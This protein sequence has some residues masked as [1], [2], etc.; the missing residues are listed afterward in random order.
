MERFI[1]NSIQIRFRLDLSSC[2]LS[3]HGL[4]K[5]ISALR[6]STEKKLKI[7]RYL[8][9][10]DMSASFSDIK[11]DVLPNV[12]ESTLY[13]YLKQLENVGLITSSYNR[14]KRYSLGSTGISYQLRRSFPRVRTIGG[15][16]KLDWNSTYI[17]RSL[18]EALSMDIDNSKKVVQRVE[19]VVTK[20]GVNSL[21]IVTIRALICDILYELG[22]ERESHDYTPIG[23]PQEKAEDISL[24]KFDEVH[25]LTVGKYFSKLFMLKLLPSSV[26]KLIERGEYIY[27]HGLTNVLNPLNVLHD[28]RPLFLEGL[29]LPDHRVRPAKSLDVAFS[30]IIALLGF[31]RNDCDGTQCINHLNFYIAPYVE[32]EKERF[33][34]GN[35]MEHLIELCDGFIKDL[36]RTYL[37]NVNDPV[38]PGVILDLNTL[39]MSEKIVVAR[40]EIMEDE[41]YERYDE[42]AEIFTEAFLEALI[43]G[44]EEQNIYYYPKIFIELNEDT[45]KNKINS[46]I[47]AKLFE[48]I[49]KSS[50][51]PIYIANRRA[52]VGYLPDLTSINVSEKGEDS[53]KGMGCM[54]AVTPN[55]LK[56]KSGIYKE[57]IDSV[58]SEIVSMIEYIKKLALWKKDKVKSRIRT[59]RIF[60]STWKS[61]LPTYY[62]IQ[63]SIACVRL[64]GLKTLAKLMGYSVEK[65]AIKELERLLYNL[66]SKMNELSQV[67]G[68]KFT[69]AQTPSKSGAMRFAK[70]GTESANLF[71]AIKTPPSDES[72]F[73]ERILYEARLQQLLDGGALTRLSYYPDRYSLER[74]REDLQICF[75]NKLK[76]ITFNRL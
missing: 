38:Y 27:I 54:L 8:S 51:T 16:K 1:S 61:A 70:I 11:T 2:G 50:P 67:T 19:E 29:S 42:Y 66:N 5:Q 26:R 39:P 28:V 17:L 73:L 45:L 6:R 34:R 32:N 63:N 43:R 76:L 48:I 30:Q 10:P 33:G 57:G 21:S 25:K 13:A 20:M 52:D 37:M 72:H 68:M 24:R 14:P 55:I 56:L 15:R 69:L 49:K 71:S 35:F 62:D 22:M 9:Q 41:N 7:L 23:I 47:F 64:L 36:F 18:S 53:F 46:S 59:F 44:L 4:Y 40:G 74:F 65:D 12:K 58:T 75:K 3:E 31:S 60:G